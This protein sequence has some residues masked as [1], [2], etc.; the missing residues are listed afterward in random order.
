MEARRA[1]P[2]SITFHNLIFEVGIDHSNKFSWCKVHEISYWTCTGAS[3]TLNAGVQRISVGGMQKI[4]YF[5]AERRFGCH[6][7]ILVPFRSEIFSLLP[8]SRACL[9][10]QEADLVPLVFRSAHLLAQ[11]SGELAV[12]EREMLSVHAYL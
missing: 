5:F 6:R 3:P 4:G 1:E 9:L 2:K 8:F 7:F 11:N 10:F 12:Q